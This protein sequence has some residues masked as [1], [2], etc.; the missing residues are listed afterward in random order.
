MTQ[1]LEKGAGQGRGNKKIVWASA[2]Q[3]ENRDEIRSGG[4]ARHMEDLV[5]PRQSWPAPILLPL[6]N[7]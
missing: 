7:P 2:H 1:T 6:V 5:V 3:A 4:L